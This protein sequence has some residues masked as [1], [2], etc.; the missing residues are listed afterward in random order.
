MNH[1]NMSSDIS[2]NCCVLEKFYNFSNA[3]H[4]RQ[5]VS[6]ATFPKYALHMITDYE[7]C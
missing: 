6:A 3:D 1:K 4:L 7:L 5:S 2:W